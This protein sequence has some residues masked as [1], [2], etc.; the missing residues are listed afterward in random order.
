MKAPRPSH[1]TQ[2]VSF[3]GPVLTLPKAL[4][5]SFAHSTSA[6]NLAWRDS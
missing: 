3:V 2:L 5:P 1:V 6:P 4:C